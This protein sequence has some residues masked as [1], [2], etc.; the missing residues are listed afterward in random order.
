MKQYYVIPQAEILEIE[1]EDAI[2]NSSVGTT[3]SWENDTIEG[4]WK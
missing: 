4:E 1:I 3:P 2:L